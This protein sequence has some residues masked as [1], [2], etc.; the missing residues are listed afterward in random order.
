MEVA[1][2]PKNIELS[3]KDK[4]NTN[5]LKNQLNILMQ[6]CPVVERALCVVHGE[7]RQS[8]T[9][10]NVVTNNCEH[11][12]SWCRSGFSISSQVAKRTEQLFKLGMVAGAAIL[13]R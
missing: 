3:L 9:P 12:A 7:D 10:Y 1:P 2:P 5:C 8:Y 13:P 6:I 4:T 11:F